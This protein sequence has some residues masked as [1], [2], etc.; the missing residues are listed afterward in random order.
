MNRFRSDR[1]RKKVMGYEIGH[2]AYPNNTLSHPER[3]S[4]VFGSNDGKIITGRIENGEAL[5][6]DGVVYDPLPS[7]HV[8]IDTAK[9]ER[10]ILVSRGDEA[11][12]RQNKKGTYQ[13]WVR[14][15]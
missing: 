14:S 12:V 5:I 6:L 10:D 4:H 15:R 11:I 3:S 7:D 2:R 8:D 13:V 1:Q 9:K